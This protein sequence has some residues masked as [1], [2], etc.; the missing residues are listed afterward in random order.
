MGSDEDNR[1]ALNP[2]RPGAGIQPAE[3]VGRAR[4]LERMDLMIARTKLHETERGV[5]YSGLRGVGKTVLL[6]RMADMAEE[7]GMC[8]A[9]IE[10]DGDPMRE[11]DALF[12]EIT[13]ASAR[14]RRTEVR[15]S[16]TEVLGRVDSASITLPGFAV[17]VTGK[18]KDRLRSDAFKL[19]LTIE[20]VS[21]ELART[22][23]G[24]FLFIDEFQSMSPELMAALLTIQHRMGQRSLPF[25][26]IGAGL[27]NL[28]GVLTKSRS[29]AERLFEYRTVGSLD[30]ADSEHG[31][32]DTAERTGRRFDDE[33]LEKLVDLSH[34]YPYFIQ[35]YGMA[36]WDAADSNP[37]GVDAVEKGAP[38]ARNVLDLG[39]YA[40]RWQRATPSGRRYLEAMASLGEDQCQSQAVAKALGKTT[41]DL[42]VVRRALIRLGLIYSPERGRIAFTVPGMAEYIRRTSPAEETAYADE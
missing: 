31:F 18:A 9:R 30:R 37:I 39:L 8:V 20:E 3:L 14:M 42:S 17:E 5:V 6:L 24:L 32:Q 4:D 16:L 28:P 21:R 13:L 38:S 40:S 35:A 7:Q 26:I 23:S 12:H 11:Y 25:L 22:G 33:A 1:K 19:E 15:Q 29:Y 36:A 34:G 27:P 41:S 2:F 10:A